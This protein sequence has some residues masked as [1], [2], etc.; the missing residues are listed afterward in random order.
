MSTSDSLS[1]SLNT[2]PTQTYT[3]DLSNNDLWDVI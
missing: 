3:S 1:D 2:E